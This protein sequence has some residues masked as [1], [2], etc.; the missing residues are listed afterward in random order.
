M[1][2]L[3]CVLDIVPD[4]VRARNITNKIQVFSKSKVWRGRP[5]PKITLMVKCE[6]NSL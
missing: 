5:V 2:G 1:E 4:S 3:L 6:F